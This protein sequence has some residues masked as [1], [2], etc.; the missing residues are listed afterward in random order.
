MKSTQRFSVLI[1]ADKRK[2]D[3]NGNV[4]LYARITYLGKR[5]EISLQ[6]KIDPKKWDAQG[7]FLKGPGQDIKNVN[8]A[9]A[10]ASNES[11]ILKPAQLTYIKRI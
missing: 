1:W 8:A 5:V 3:A 11:L 10:E 7:W 2:T 9:I 6:R 4:P